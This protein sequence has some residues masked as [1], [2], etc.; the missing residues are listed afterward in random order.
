MGI[1]LHEINFIPS[2]SGRDFLD[3]AGS[4][5]ELCLEFKLKT[6]TKIGCPHCHRVLVH[7]G[8]HQRTLKNLWGHKNTVKLPRVKCSNQECPAV[9]KNKCGRSTHVIYPSTIIPYIHYHVPEIILLFLHSFNYQNNLLRQ[10]F[11]QLKNATSTALYDAVEYFSCYHSE[12]LSRWRTWFDVR[13]K[14]IYLHITLNYHDVFRQRSLF[15]RFWI[16]DLC[17]CSQSPLRLKIPGTYFTQSISCLP[18]KIN[19]GTGPPRRL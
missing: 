6:G 16:I 5:I 7:C 9:K 12:L 1:I 17:R 13:V 10:L 11:H 19:S 4:D 3:N 8:V 18:P 2:N 14:K 15:A